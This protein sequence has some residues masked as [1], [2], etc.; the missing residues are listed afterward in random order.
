MFDRRNKW[1]TKRC[2]YVC[3]Y[4]T[5]IYEIREKEQ[6]SVYKIVV[7]AF[8]TLITIYKQMHQEIMDDL[9]SF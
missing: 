3:S 1:I 9:G 4:E 5:K 7:A 2:V 8:Y 6:H